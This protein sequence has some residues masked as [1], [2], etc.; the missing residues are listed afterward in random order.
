M[1]EYNTDQAHALL[2]EYF[3]YDEFRPGQ[4]EIISA[5]VNGNNT[6]GIMPTG[7]G[8]SM[9][10]QIPA[11]MM[12]GLT[13]VVSP[14]ISLM[15][16]QVDS[17]KEMGIPAGMINSSLE[18]DD[19]FETIRDA[20]NLKYKL[21]YIAPERLENPA[22][23]EMLQTM[24][25]DLVAI[26]EAHCMS[27]WGHDFRPSYLELGN[28]IPQI[29]TNPTVVAL[30][31]TATPK[32]ALDIKNNLGIPKNNEVKTGFARDNL[33]FKVIKGVQ[34]R[35]Y[36]INYLRSH[37][38]ESGIIYAATRSEVDRIAVFLQKLGIKAKPYHAQHTAEER[39]EAQDDFTFDRVQ[40]IVATNAFGMGIDKSNVR[41]VIHAQ[42]PGSIEAYY[43]EAGRAGRDGL[44]SEAI[45]LYRDADI[46]LRRTW[47]DASEANEAHRTREYDKLEW[48]RRYANTEDC[49]QQFIVRYFGGDCEPCGK[50]SNC[51][52]ERDSEDITIEAQKV[53]SCVVRLNQRFGKKIVAQVLKG[54]ST[55]RIL[56]MNLD[57]VTT[58]GIMKAWTLKEIE[59][60]IDYLAASQYLMTQSGQFPTLLLTQKGLTVLKG[61]EKV[62]RKVDRIVEKEVEVD[63]ELFERLRELRL[64]IA[65][66]QNTAPFIIFSDKALKDMCE[67]LPTTDEEFLNV[68][69]VGQ[70]KLENYGPEFMEA[71]EQWKITHE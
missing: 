9:C 54:S 27:Q 55:Q 68:K 29:T 70:S 71:I 19:F 67:K 20:R 44:E 35:D 40:V 62:T 4:E 46:G 37:E 63:N 50:C 51:L 18:G 53:L 26:D 69:G 33:A 11:L 30:T 13:I 45:L 57:E 12:D 7:G 5:V 47:I 21:L 49:L 34:S 2:K 66:D 36:I 65:R 15:K 42:T 1:R 52:D 6:L 28:V 10:Y 61:Q 60:L 16:D 48:M 23:M 8:K 31:A 14:L 25:I 56:E 58:Y 64:E 24:P 22:F 43:Q 39:Q 3:G 41:F 32:V 59:N 38:K 17:L